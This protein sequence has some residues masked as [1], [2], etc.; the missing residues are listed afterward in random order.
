MAL[1]DWDDVRLFLSLLEA[2][3][4]TAGAKA[5]G[6]DV[7]TASRRLARLEERL[8]VPLFHRTREGLA[9]T[10]AATRLLPA[11]QAMAQAAQTFTGEAGGLEREVEGVVSLSLPPGIGEAFIA[12]AL[13]ALSARY[14]RLRF[15]VDASTRLRDVGRR[16]VDL[17]LRTIRPTAG[18]LKVQRL[19][20][21]KWL[22]M[23]APAVAAR[24][25]K[26]TDWA[27]LRWVGWGFELAH[28][29][30]AAWLSARVKAALLLRTN[31]FG[32][33]V[34][35]VREG[36]GVALVPEPYAAV[37][38][39]DVLRVSRRLA[40]DVAALPTDELWLVA[41]EG[42]REVPHVAATWD[43]LVASFR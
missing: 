23:A 38:G 40:S 9:P 21:A 37:Y 22:P 6:V 43:F 16:E 28:L 42:L 39:F 26:V 2:R 32:L 30:V 12:P 4:L 27:S 17:A 14:P 13:P 34:A 31:A 41:H 10:K 7:S 15:E 18:P 11:A 25:G 29:P 3:S 36:L 8:E 20:R 24:L 35:A 33:Q 1:D 5:L 19:T